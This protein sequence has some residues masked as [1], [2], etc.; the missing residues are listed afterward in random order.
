M[1]EGRVGGTGVIAGLG[2]P[3]IDD[4]ELTVRRFS[5]ESVQAENEARF[6]QHVTAKLANFHPF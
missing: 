4:A 6:G 2:I 1:L 5:Q 3:V